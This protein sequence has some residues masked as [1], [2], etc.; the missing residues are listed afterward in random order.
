M[1]R[2][3]TTTFTKKAQINHTTKLNTILQQHRAIQYSHN[4]KRLKSSNQFI[5]LIINPTKQNTNIQYQQL[6]LLITKKSTN[7]QQ[8]HQNTTT[9]DQNK[10]QPPI[11]YNISNNTLLT[12]IQKL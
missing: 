9:N 11:Q 2:E 3:F 5:F 8:L 10:I 7:S 6:Q 4:N 12:Q 1:E